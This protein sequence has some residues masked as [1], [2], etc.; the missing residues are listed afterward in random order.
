[1]EG[2]IHGKG[3]K[4]VILTKTKTCSFMFD[5][6]ILLRGIQT[7]VLTIT[8]WLLYNCRTVTRFNANLS[9]LFN[10]LEHDF[11]LKLC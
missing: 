3:I 11:G 9:S 5:C 7:L 6:N 4:H 2:V 10:G 1:M 8:E